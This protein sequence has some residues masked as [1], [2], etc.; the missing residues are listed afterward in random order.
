MSHSCMYDSVVHSMSR[1]CMYD[2]A[3]FLLLQV[4]TKLLVILLPELNEEVKVPFRCLWRCPE[5]GQIPLSLVLKPGR[6]IGW[7]AMA[8]MKDFGEFIWFFPRYKLRW[9]LRGSES[10]NRISSAI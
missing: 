5:E 3:V 4:H 7:G 10:E 2:L 6:L 1:F 9:S 8:L